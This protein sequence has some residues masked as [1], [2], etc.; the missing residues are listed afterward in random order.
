MS[1]F[2]SPFTVKNGEPITI[3][4]L[5]HRHLRQ[6]STKGVEE[7]YQVEYKTAL[8]DSAKRKIPK[9][10]TSFAN[11]AGGWLFVGVDETTLEIDKL[12]KPS[13]IDFNQI[14]S[15]ILRE[16]VSPLP[17]FDTRFLKSKGSSF[18]VLVV[19]IYEGNNPP[20]VADGIVYIRNG[21]SSEPAKSQRSKINNLYQKRKDFE[22]KIKDF[23]KRE[24]Y[25]PMD[26]RDSNQVV[27][28]NIY[29]MKTTESFSQSSS[30][31]LDDLAEK[32]H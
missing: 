11:S 4:H 26:D 31:S 15:P 6:L 10:I 5:Q 1:F 7:G 16:H 3:S 25:Y 12:E 24:I 27:L 21:S 18:G 9:I 19:Y 32:I 22:A 17:R 23:C 28:C 13:R 29:I 8:T 14:I 2:Y 20:Y 30:I